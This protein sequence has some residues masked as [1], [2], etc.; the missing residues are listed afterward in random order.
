M[1]LP[2]QSLL[3]QFQFFVLHFMRILDLVLLYIYNHRVKP[4]QAPSLR[5]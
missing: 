4:R 2:E 3:N 1:L 5:E